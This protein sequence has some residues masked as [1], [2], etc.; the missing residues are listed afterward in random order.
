MAGE[1]LAVMPRPPL[2][3]AVAEGVDQSCRVRQVFADTPPGCTRGVRPR[4]LDAPYVILKK[5]TYKN[6]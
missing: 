5:I 3:V 1:H 4:G 6:Q 2:Q